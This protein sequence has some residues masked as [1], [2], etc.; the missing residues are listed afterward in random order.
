MYIRDTK[1]GAIYAISATHYAHLT[2]PQWED[3]KRE[4]AKATDLP[5]ELVFHYCKSRVRV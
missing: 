1:T 4:G 3:R 5:P 2:G